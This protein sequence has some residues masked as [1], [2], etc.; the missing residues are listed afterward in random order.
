MCRKYVISSSTCFQ[1]HD[2]FD[3][4]VIDVKTTYESF[5]MSTTQPYIVCCGALNKLQCCHVVISDLKYTFDNV[6][7]A[8]DFL[9]KSFFVL[10][11]PYSCGCAHVWTFFQRNVYNM[12]SARKCIAKRQS[13]ELITELDKIAKKRTKT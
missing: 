6:V 10:G 5:E 2:Q 8:V 3:K 13:E 1:K 4:L 7:K 12:D 11:I 9:Y